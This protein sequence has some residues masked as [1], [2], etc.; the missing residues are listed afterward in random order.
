MKRKTKISCAYKRFTH[1]M[2]F[3]L[4]DTVKSIVQVFRA[5]ELFF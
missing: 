1:R 2:I 3:T 5:S 4:L